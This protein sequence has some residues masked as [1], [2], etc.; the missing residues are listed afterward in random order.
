MSFTVA[1][2]TLMDAW[3]HHQGLH[4][5]NATIAELVES[6]VRLDAARSQMSQNRNI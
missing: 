1:F 2:N 5:D 3:N 4:T 6:R